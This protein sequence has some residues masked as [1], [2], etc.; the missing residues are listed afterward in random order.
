[1]DGLS[2]EN[3]DIVMQPGDVITEYRWNGW[4]AAPTFTNSPV[5]R[6]TAPMPPIHVPESEIATLVQDGIGQFE[7]LLA[8]T[9]SA[10]PTVEAASPETPVQSTEAR[11]S[12]EHL[13]MKARRVSTILARFQ[14][15]QPAEVTATVNLT[16]EVPNE[17][18]PAAE[19]PRLDRLRRVGRFIHNLVRRGPMLAEA[20]LNPAYDEAWYHSSAVIDDPEGPGSLRAGVIPAPTFAHEMPEPN[21]PY[22][23]WDGQDYSLLDAESFHHRNDPYYITHRRNYA[24]GNQAA[25]GSHPYFSSSERTSTSDGQADFLTGDLRPVEYGHT[26][27][28]SYAAPL[29]WIVLSRILSENELKAERSRQIDPVQGID[30]LLNA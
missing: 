26:V 30:L 1:M 23:D 11:H 16:P 17:A 20:D 28:H 13:R 18:V 10:G 7:E 12:V 19:V 25:V 14:P 21:V 22:P 29:G 2:H 3:P 24:V 27:E 9:A 6:Q 15:K 4:F 5:D 8:Q